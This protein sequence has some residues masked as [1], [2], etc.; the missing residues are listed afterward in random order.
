MTGACD[1]GIWQGVENSRLLWA[2]YGV[3]VLNLK[4]KEKEKE[5]H[6]TYKPM[7]PINLFSP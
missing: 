1:P 5:N 2:T 3:A 6:K 4:K 7:S